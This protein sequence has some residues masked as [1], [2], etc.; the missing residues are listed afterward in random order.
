MGDYPDIL[1]TLGQGKPLKMAAVGGGCIADT[2]LATFVDGSRVFV[3][4]R[5]KSLSPHMFKCEAQGLKALAEPG[6]LRVPNV[7]AVDENALVLEYI[8]S[9]PAKPGFDEAFGSGLADLHR[10]RAKTFGF[11]ADNFIGASPQRNDP[12]GCSWGDAEENDGSAWPVFYLERRLR[13]Q[14]DLARQNGHGDELDQLLDQA[15]SNIMELLAS[16]PERPGLLHGDLW[17]GNYLVDDR[18]VACLIDPAVYYGHRETDLAMTRLFGGFSSR[19]Y[20]A[21]HE[22]WP[23]APGHEE[24]LALYQ[25]YHVLNH[26][27]LFGGS[28]YDQGKKIL[29]RYAS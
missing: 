5:G 16:A 6:A 3:K 24:R 9:A 28:Y 7:L 25:L 21:Y 8:E 10:C 27:N 4:T 17:G 23:L 19:F 20:A 11:P 29:Q 1:D 2:R 22:A 18:G 13:F 12:V 14:T 15:E 26:L